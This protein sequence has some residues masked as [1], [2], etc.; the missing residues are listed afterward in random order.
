MAPGTRILLPARAQRGAPGLRR[1][2][3][4]GHNR[5]HAPLVYAAGE[6]DRGEVDG[7]DLDRLRRGIRDAAYRIRLV[8]EVASSQSRAATASRTSSGGAAVAPS[9]TRGARARGGG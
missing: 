5:N 3:F 6:P 4:P 7:M 2:G 9:R 8:L 1:A